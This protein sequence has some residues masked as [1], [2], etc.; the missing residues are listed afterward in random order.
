MKATAKATIGLLFAAS[1]VALSAM[2]HG[3]GKCEWNSFY[4][5]VIGP[6]IAMLLIFCLP[7]QQSRPRSIAGCVAAFAVL[8]FTGLSYIG[9]MWISVSSMSALIFLFEPLYLFVGGL[10]VWVLTWVLLAR[11]KSEHA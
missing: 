9:A 11:R 6:Y 4:L 7:M 5:W 3:A 8:F 2:I 1:V 10:A